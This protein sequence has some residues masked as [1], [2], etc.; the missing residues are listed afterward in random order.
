MKKL[1]IFGD[2]HS[3][4][5]ILMNALDEK[6]YD[7]NDPD[8]IL[9]SLGDLCDRGEQSKEIL[10][11][12]NSIPKDRK[13][14]IAGNH[15]CLMERMIRRGVPT[16]H[17]IHNCTLQTAEQLTGETGDEAVL[18]MQ[19]CDLWNEYRKDWVWYAELNDMIFVHGWIPCDTV[20]TKRGLILDASYREN[21]RESKA[22]DFEQAAWINGMNAW[23]LG[24]RE[25]GKTIYC[26][27]WHTSWGHANLRNDGKEFLDK[28]DTYHTREDGTVWPYARFDP[29][30][31]EGIVAVDACTVV[32]GKVNVVVREVDDIDDLTAVKYEHL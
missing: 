5:D 24:I 4:F 6:G 15:E 14:C 31:D 19:F 3:F 29:F 25:P 7:R 11:F 18:Q 22:S 12:I 16:P 21:W 17:D 9:V 20:R 1:F 8:H 30:E 28:V 10:E 2:P 32:S 27:H 26:C 13:I 23:Y